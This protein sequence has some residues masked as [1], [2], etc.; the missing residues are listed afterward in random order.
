MIALSFCREIHAHCEF[1]IN[2]TG[3]RLVLPNTY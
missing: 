1:D 2:M 3:I